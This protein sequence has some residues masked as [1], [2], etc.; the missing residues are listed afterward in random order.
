MVE[1]KGSLSFRYFNFFFNSRL[2]DG[3]YIVETKGSL[4]FRIVD[5]VEEEP[6][7]I[8]VV[9]L[10]RDPPIM[11]RTQVKLIKLYSGYVRR[12]KVCAPRIDRQLAG[13]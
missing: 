3:R 9:Q 6:Y 12:M 2:D 8:A 1:T 10:L 7:P 5:I 13:I 4:P 11:Q